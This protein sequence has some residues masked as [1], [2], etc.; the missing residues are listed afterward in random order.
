MWYDGG[1]EVFWFGGQADKE[2][3]DLGYSI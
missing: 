3:K 1:V 2:I